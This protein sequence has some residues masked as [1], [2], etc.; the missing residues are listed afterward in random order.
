MYRCNSILGAKPFRPTSISVRSKESAR[1]IRMIEEIG[2]G[3]G[4]CS[5]K[6]STALRALLKPR[7]PSSNLLFC[8]VA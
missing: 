5:F 2:G 3:F 8:L 7:P 1:W 6:S 4:I